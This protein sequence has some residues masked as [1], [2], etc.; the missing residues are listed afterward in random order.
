MLL[1]HIF[2]WQYLIKLKWFVGLGTDRETPQKR[3]AFYHLDLVGVTEIRY[4]VLHFLYWSLVPVMF[5][6]RHSWAEVLLILTRCMLLNPFWFLFVTPPPLFFTGIHWPE[7]T[8]STER[9]E[10]SKGENWRGRERPGS[11]KVMDTPFIAMKQR[12]KQLLPMHVF[13]CFPL[14]IYILVAEGSQPSICRLV[15]F[16]QRVQFTPRRSECKAY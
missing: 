2:L 11:R 4:I 9:T 12:L 8:E 7:I 15:N 6:P 1:G 5:I 14:C 16:Q 13:V 10:Q 3:W